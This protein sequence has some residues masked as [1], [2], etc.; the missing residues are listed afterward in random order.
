MM[1]ASSRL[2]FLCLWERATAAG[3]YLCSFYSLCCCHGEV[4]GSCLTSWLAFRLPSV[5]DK[6]PAGQAALEVQCQSRARRFS[7]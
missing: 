4:R 3:R 1:Q 6:P 2:D 5:P 7:G